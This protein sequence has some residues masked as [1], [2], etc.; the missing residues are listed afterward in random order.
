MEN[1]NIFLFKNRRGIYKIFDRKRNRYYIGSSINLYKR[2]N[3]HLY[4]LKSNIHSNPF[5]QNHVNKYGLDSL[6]VEILQIVN[7][8]MTP[9]QLIDLEQN[10]LD[11]Y[12]NETNCF[13]IVD[14]AQY[15]NSDTAKK[16][17]N[18]GIKKMWENNYDEMKLKVMKNLKKAKLIKKELI[19]KGLYEHNSWNKGLKTPE[20]TKLKQ[21]VSAIKRGR[22]TSV[23][24]YQYSL[25]GLYI[26]KY[27]AIA[28]A[29]RFYNKPLKIGSNITAC[30]RNKRKTTFGFLW[31]Y[32]KKDNYYIY[33]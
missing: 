14:T 28:D 9:R 29:C 27:E 10:Y 21:A 15:I 32:K 8:K 11:T 12:Y 26:T 30:C 22:N 33:K 13:N 6:K 17:T 5:L 18:E 7:E 3:S 16:K 19:K 20:I 4:T 31:S 1:L 23:S 25:D 24:V 2:I